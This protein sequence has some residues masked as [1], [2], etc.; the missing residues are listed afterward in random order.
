META[1]VQK[2]MSNIAVNFELCLW[3]IHDITAVPYGMVT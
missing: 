2:T 1:G 3:I